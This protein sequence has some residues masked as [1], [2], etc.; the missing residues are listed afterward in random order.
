PAACEWMSTPITLSSSRAVSASD[1]STSGPR[2]AQA[3]SASAP[4][5][6]T[7]SRRFT[8]PPAPTPLDL[9][10]PLRALRCALG[11]LLRL[12]VARRGLRDQADDDEV[13]GGSGG[14]VAQAPR[15]AGR[16]RELARVAVGQ[17]FGVGCPDGFF[18]VRHQRMRGIPKPRLQPRAVL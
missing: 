15:V 9:V 11:G 6:A 17:G 16:P 7:A 12:L 10:V 3:P 1:S 2:D 18:L 4:R 8:R 14:G 5:A 13:G